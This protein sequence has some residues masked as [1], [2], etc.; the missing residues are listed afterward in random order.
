[1][2]TI[3]VGTNRKNSRT[4]EVAQYYQNLLR[5]EKVESQ[6]LDLSELPD[7]FTTSALYENTGKNPV[8]NALR[9]TVERADQYVFIVP[10]YNGSFPGVLKAFLDG[11]SYP[12]KLM[13]KQA[14]LVGLSDGIQGGALALSH[15]NDIFS[16][17]GLN[18]LAQRVKIPLMKKNFQDGKVTDDFINQLLREQAGL[19]AR[20]R[21]FV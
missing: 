13:H 21:L 16:Y 5:Q 19:L 2:I 7:D 12:S 11:L 1:M 15:L 10:E 3:V 9:T 18:V 6:I 17:L 14:A 8:F 4:R 20:S